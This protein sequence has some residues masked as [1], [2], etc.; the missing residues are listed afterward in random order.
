MKRWQ[1]EDYSLLSPGQARCTNA[2][3]LLLARP[4]TCSVD[5][6]ISIGRCLKLPLSTHVPWVYTHCGVIVGGV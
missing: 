5:S 4:F 6:T 2:P 3:T 1:Q